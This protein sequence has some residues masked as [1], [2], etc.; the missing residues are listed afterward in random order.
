MENILNS[1]KIFSYL[2]AYKKTQAGF[3]L[4]TEK[5]SPWGTTG[6]TIEPSK[7]GRHGMRMGVK[8]RMALEVAITGWFSF[9][10]CV[11]RLHSGWVRS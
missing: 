3:K 9:H 7:Y 10:D 2:C 4:I 5:N 6:T 8:S 11:L 1:I